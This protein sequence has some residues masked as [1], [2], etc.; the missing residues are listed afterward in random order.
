MTSE[1]AAGA[2]RFP[3]TNEARPVIG[4][5]HLMPL[6][7]SPRYGGSFEDVVAAAVRDAE[8]LAEGGISAIMI[9]N[10]GDVPFFPARVPT[11]AV[12]HMTHVA[13]EIARR[14]DVPLGINVLRND[15]VTAMSIAAAVGAAFVRVNVLSGARVTDQGVIEGIA[16]D[17]LRQRSRLGCDSVQ[18]L[19][20]VDVKHSAPLAARPLADEVQDTIARGCAD[21]VIVSGS[22]TGAETP[23]ESVRQVKA[24]AGSTPVLIGSG[25]TPET[26]P[27]L[28]Q[29]AD[30]VIVGTWL[31]RGGRVDEPVDVA[32][33]RELMGKG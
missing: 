21:A 20:D 12:T 4:M 25:V 7:G 3:W 11:E 19:A 10:F 17:L 24:A 26:L 23:L 6:P 13:G 32:R 14:I 1:D 31:K 16:H 5:V 2:A 30:G 27:G 18:I 33:V 29:E 15:G 22:G 8:A 9:E 28:L